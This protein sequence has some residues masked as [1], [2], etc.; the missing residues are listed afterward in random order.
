M[1]FKTISRVV[2]TQASAVIS[3]VNRL[4]M[5]NLDDMAVQQEEEEKR[6]LLE[7]EEE[8][9]EEE[10]DEDI[11]DQNDN[12]IVFPSIPQPSENFTASPPFLKH[13]HNLSMSSID[14]LALES[15]VVTGSDIEAGDTSSAP[16]DS[17][18]QQADDWSPIQSPPPKQVVSEISSVVKAS[19][20]KIKRKKEKYKKKKKHLDFFGIRSAQDEEEEEEEQNA[21]EEDN[22]NSANAVK[23]RASNLESIFDISNLWDAEGGIEDVPLDDPI[24]TNPSNPAGSSSSSNPPGDGSSAPSSSFIT[25]IFQ[26]TTN[27]LRVPVNIKIPTTNFSFFSNVDTE[28]DLE[29]DPILKK[30]E[31]NKK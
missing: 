21:V 16:H 4:E 9:E 2:S 14:N 30:V 22:S 28:V 12:P 7:E 29:N 23:G 17:I 31:E 1:T 25:D 18:M 19:G 13:P 8:E 24:T 3:T 11:N 27:A 10:D 15:V 5:L 20:K 6:R 26:S